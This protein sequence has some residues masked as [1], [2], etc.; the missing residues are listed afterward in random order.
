MHATDPKYRQNC[1]VFCPFFL[2]FASI[3]YF[4]FDIL[5]FYLD[6]LSL[7]LPVVA[8]LFTCL[9]GILLIFR[10]NNAPFSLLRSQMSKDL[11]SA[12]DSFPLDGLFSWQDARR[13]W[14]L[15]LMTG[16]SVD[17]LSPQAIIL[18]LAMFLC[19]GPLLVVILF[20]MLVSGTARELDGNLGILLALYCA[21]SIWAFVESCLVLHQRIRAGRQ[22]RLA[23]YRAGG[24]YTAPTRPFR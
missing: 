20:V 19:S 7:P 2:L 17:Q 22:R 15:S 16:A 10:I 1:H 12:T 21:L 9:V 6:V 11:P 13:I 4:F 3:H 24:G 23:R 18:Y 5:N 8:H 14:S